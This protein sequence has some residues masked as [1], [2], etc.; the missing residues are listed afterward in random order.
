V[1]LP[2]LVRERTSRSRRRRNFQPEALEGR[3]LLSV[4]AA[5][6]VVPP[7]F[8]YAEIASTH[9]TAD[10][11][12]LQP[13][14]NN[15]STVAYVYS[16]R[17]G[18]VK[19]LTSDSTTIADLPLFATFDASPPSINDRGTVAFSTP[20]DVFTGNG[21]PLTTIAHVGTNNINNF[22]SIPS[23]NSHGLVAFGA[24]LTTAQDAIFTGNGGSLTTAV[25]GGSGSLQDAGGPMLNNHGAIAFTEDRGS[26]LGFGGFTIDKGA[27]KV[28]AENS[29]LTIIGAP[30]A[31]NNSGEVAFEASFTQNSQFKS[32]VFVGSAGATPV[33]DATASVS[34][35]PAINK[36][37][38]VAF[39]TFDP[40]TGNPV[41]ELVPSP[42]AAPI[43]VLKGGDAL[44]GSTV[45][46]LGFSSY[47]LS[48]KDAL[49]F[50][51]VLADGRTVIVQATPTRLW[52]SGCG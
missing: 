15:K 12:G 7:R 29:S 40:H 10:S 11:L 3:N 21:G 16:P 4:P 9:G 36:S 24:H 37:G 20:T 48:D 41:L 47:G 27:Q 34:G 42:G 26:G 31:I 30:P 22:F 44:F 6:P 2:F 8:T 46:Q 49:A 28:I 39:L 14:I 17:L 13:A 5:A 43:V 35:S 18:E 23:I 51:A 52:P 25:T 33:L 32:G 50:G 38:A 45:T 1:K 19:V